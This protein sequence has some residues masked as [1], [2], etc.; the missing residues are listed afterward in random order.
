MFATDENRSIGEKLY[1]WGYFF[2][3]SPQF[4]RYTVKFC[5]FFMLLRSFVS[6]AESVGMLPVKI[7]SLVEK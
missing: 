7:G 5:T 1:Y 4:L 6:L 3:K 2:M